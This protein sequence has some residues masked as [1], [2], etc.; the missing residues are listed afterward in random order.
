MYEMFIRDREDMS[1]NGTLEQC[2]FSKQKMEDINFKTKESIGTDLSKTCKV[3]GNDVSENNLVEKKSKIYCQE[4]YEKKKAKS[5]SGKFKSMMQTLKPDAER[6]KQS[7][8]SV[9]ASSF[10]EEKKEKKA[11]DP[12]APKKSFLTKAQEKLNKMDKNTILGYFGKGEK[13]EEGTTGPDEI[14]RSSS[15][16]PQ[17]QPPSPTISPQASFVQE[18]PFPPKK[19]PPTYPLGKSAS[20]GRNSLPEGNPSKLIATQYDGPKLQSNPPNNIPVSSPGRS[21]RN[22]GNNNP[23]SLNPSIPVNSTNNTPVNTT[24]NNPSN[25]EPSVTISTKPLPKPP[26]RP[27]NPSQLV[28]RPPVS[29]VSENGS[30]QNDTADTLQKKAQNKPPVQRPAEPQSV[31]ALMEQ[32]ADSLCEGCKKPLGFNVAISS[33]LGKTWH[34]NCFVCFHCGRVFEGSFV[35][36]DG[37]CYHMECLKQLAPKCMKCQRPLSGRV[38]NDRG[39]RYHDTCFVPANQEFRPPG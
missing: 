9:P 19:E 27:A 3:C 15:P 26:P 37:S 11:K 33:A 10:V 20:L 39:N 24:Q 35:Q 31:D 2:V 16:P 5:A 21:P 32:S 8:T 4:C 14:E 38:I 30:R 12:D 13:S 28:N 25:R 23:K 18:R 29:T 34:K 36:K 22:D 17:P 1:K 6:P 7:Q